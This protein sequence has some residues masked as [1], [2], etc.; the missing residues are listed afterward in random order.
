MRGRDGRTC[1]PPCAVRPRT[2]TLRHMH[3]PLRSAAPHLQ[4]VAGQGRD[5]LFIVPPPPVGTT[6]GMKVTSCLKLSHPGQRAAEQRRD[7]GSRDASRRGGHE[8][9]LQYPSPPGGNNRVRCPPMASFDP[10]FDPDVAKVIREY[11]GLGTARS[12]TSTANLS[13]AR[14]TKGSVTTGGKKPPL[15]REHL[16]ALARVANEYRARETPDRYAKWL[17]EEAAKRAD[18]P[19]AATFCCTGGSQTA[20]L[21]SAL[22]LSLN[23]VGPRSAAA[24]GLITGFKTAMTQVLRKG[25]MDLAIAL[26]EALRKQPKALA[27]P[28]E[29]RAVVAYELAARLDPSLQRGSTHEAHATLRRYQKQKA[30]LKRRGRTFEAESVFFPLPLLSATGA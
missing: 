30:R 23:A 25:R 13:A 19:D 10:Y 4:R 27:V 16:D 26:G 12:A 24:R 6:N 21:F 15:R 20:M 18:R 2:C 11:F 29:V 9:A 3:A 1:M 28:E 8:V 22:V 17:C 14:S 7:L 5:L